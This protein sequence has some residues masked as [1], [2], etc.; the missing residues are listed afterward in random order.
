MLYLCF[1]TDDEQ[2]IQLSI[3]Y[4]QRGENDNWVY[5]TIADLARQHGRTQAG[6]LKVVNQACI[7][8]T[9]VRC[10]CGRRLVTTSRT[11][12]QDLQRRTISRRK[13]DPQWQ[14]A[15][16]VEEL[17]K[18]QQRQQ[19]E[20]RATE[21]KAIQQQIQAWAEQLK[22]RSYGAASFRDAYFL[23]GLFSASGD[24][25]TQGTLEAWSSHRTALF[26]HPDDTLAVYQRLHEAGWIVPVQTRRWAFKLNADGVVEYDASLVNWILAPDSDHLPFTQVLLSLESTLEQATLSD[27][28]EVWYSVCLSELRKLLDK[29]LDRYNFSCKRWSPLIEQNL[30]QILDECSLAESMRIVH[31]SVRQLVDAREDKHKNYSRKYIENMLPGSFKRRLEYIRTNGWTPYRW[32]RY[33]TK[34]EAIFTSLLFNKVLKGGNHFYNELTGAAFHLEP[35]NK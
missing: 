31:G 13:V 27:W 2:L 1:T 8:V 32:N 15:T 9:T 25:W 6:L 18:E 23:Y 14:C 21:E 22:P 3:D 26:A 30:R 16:C 5:G 29:Q 24:L 34:D 19:E 20:Q 10:G 11:G 4:W 28:R 12:F 33:G 35:P 7:A 17:R